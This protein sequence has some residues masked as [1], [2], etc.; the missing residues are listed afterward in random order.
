[1]EIMKSI[2][3]FAGGLGMFIYGMHLLA[4]GLQQAAGS[5]AR[6]LMAFLTGNRLA[7]VFT[8]AADRKSVV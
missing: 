8:G 3:A 5:R 1:M 6:K 2:L 7:A 4:E